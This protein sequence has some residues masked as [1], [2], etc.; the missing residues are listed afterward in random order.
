MRYALLTCAVLTITTVLGQVVPG[1]SDYSGTGPTILRGLVRTPDDGALCV[2][3]TLTNGGTNFDLLV[4]RVD[5]AGDTLWAR[6][7][8]GSGNEDGAGVVLRGDTT[9]IICG[10]TS[11]VSDVANQSDI[12]VLAVDLN[13]ELLWHTVIR[14]PG[15]DYAFALAL[16]SDGG[17]IV[18]GQLV[19]DLERPALIKLNASGQLVWCRKATMGGWGADIVALENGEFAVTGNVFGG[20]SGIDQ[21]VMRIDGAGNVLW[22]EV[23]VGPATEYGTCIIEE[24]SGTLLVGGVSHASNG[25]PSDLTLTRLDSAGA[26]LWG[27]SMDNPDGDWIVDLIRRADG[28]S[29]GLGYSYAYGPEG[30]LLV[31][32]VDTTLGTSIHTAPDGD[33]FLYGVDNAADGG[34]W[35]CGE[36][37]G[38]IG[39]IMRLDPFLEACP[40]CAS[41]TQVNAS[42]APLSVFPQ[43]LVFQPA[44]YDTTFA[45]TVTSFE[46]WTPHCITTEVMASPYSAIS[47]SWI[48]WGEST[49]MVHGTGPSVSGTWTIL[50]LAGRCL[51]TGDLPRSTQVIDTGFRNTGLYLLRVQ[52]VGGPQWVE[53]FYW[54]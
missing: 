16:T 17:C 52:Q 24:P 38:G 47:T 18:T 19:E 20:I 35:L 51:A 32:V 39:R 25:D 15:N 5:A 46:G 42:G 34:L 1:C 13:G 40:E 2:G 8:A 33:L 29:L 49:L 4:V 23:L 6:V 41:R 30:A 28:S 26:L 53:R 50:D 9:A 54:P 12:W 36:R 48:L 21:V 11:T 31:Q 45:L 3:R 43:P 44:G 7:F 37:A 22:S 27:T 10:R 14:S